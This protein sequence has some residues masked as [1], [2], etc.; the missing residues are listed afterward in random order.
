MPLI[1]QKALE[2]ILRDV[3]KPGRYTGGEWNASA[4]DPAAADI[5]VVLAFPDVYEIGMSHLGQKIL[6][7][8]LNERPDV[9]A[10]RVFA[11]W[12]DFERGLR[13][14]GLPLHS[15]E[16]RIPL[17]EFDILGFSLLYELN[18]TNILT[19]L[20]LGGL[21]VL[22]ARRTVG[23]P[24][25]VAGGPACFNPEPLADIFDIFLIGDGEEGFLEIIEVFR[26][27]KKKRS[28]KHRLLRALSAV[29]GVYVP[30]FYEAVPSRSSFYLVPR[31]RDGAPSKVEKR[32]LRGF[33]TSYFPEKIVV[34]NIRAVFDR[35][36]VEAARGCPQACR[37]CQ[38]SVLYSPFRV[39][40]PSFLVKTLLESVM[41]T[42]YESS[43][44]TALSVG[45]YPCLEETVRNLMI[46]LEE[47]AVSLSLSSLRPKALSDGI[48]ENIVKVR[49][50]GFTLVPE[51]GTERLR[52][53]I[54]KDLREEDIREALTY[55]FNRGWNLVKLY[56][57][58]GLPTE[59][60]DDLAGIAELIREGVALG[61]T[62]LKSPPRFHVSL[63]SFIPK[64]HTPF[65]WLAMDG[66][67]VLADKIHFV[68]SAAGK[69]RSVEFKDHAVETSILEA[70]F[71]RG[72]RRLTP[73]LLEAWKR[74]ARF[75]GWGDRLDRSVWD[76]AFQAC[77][78]DSERYLGAVP[79][80]AELPW[81][82]IDTG[83]D[84]AHL[85]RELDAAL[86]E[87]RTSPCRDRHC[88]ACLGCRF[89]EDKAQTLSPPVVGPAS[90]RIPE[91]EPAGVPAGSTV[92]YRAYY[93]KTGRAR[94]LSHIDL[95]HIIQRSFRRA[96][97]EVEKTRGFHPKPRMVYGPALPLGMEADREVLEFRL[98]RRMT[99]EDFLFRVNRAVPE[100][101]RFTGL[102]TVEDGAPSLGASIRELRYSLDLDT[103]EILARLRE[104]TADDRPEAVLEWAS[105]R[106]DEEKDSRPAAVLEIDAENRRMAL[107]TPAEPGKGGRAQD[108]V[109]A[110][111]GLSHAVHFLR[112]E[113]VVMAEIDSQA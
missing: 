37:F 99:E 11:P 6:Y 42:G 51:A 90:A 82:V 16:N 102:E 98:P 103:E 27:E 66:A 18:F 38:A 70:V 87:R 76:Q 74:G 8:L 107:R 53:V 85:L 65:Q 56:F 55:A 69:M 67:A 94:F 23:R 10:E 7:G 36:A 30:S 52:R 50:T 40:E 48:A 108:I 92:R 45:D 93:G 111:L 79:G 25:V 34:P 95:I 63:S 59:R 33:K 13:E 28:G 75:D 46:H 9:A 62:I 2:K 21:P 58:V 14:T 41:Q 101:V 32:I 60:E 12:P 91:I 104:E 86:A 110:L 88:S 20:D 47:K 89:S 54:N 78:V 22:S 84:K 105:R 39:K 100:G 80:G 43:S 64:P 17:A 5:R 112:R 29:P 96:G 57:M 73:V 1:S 26:N 109:S 4:K 15:L 31:P 113:A 106:I 97:I 49:K 44:L 72:D 81:D 24:L 19:I 83:I 61:R 3:E 68:K 71:S 77:G 35:V